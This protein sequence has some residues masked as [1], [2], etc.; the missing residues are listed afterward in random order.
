MR[1]D[2]PHPDVGQTWADRLP[3]HFSKTP[4]TEY[5]R[6]K[7]LGEDNVEV[8]ADWLGMSAEEVAEKQ[9]QGIVE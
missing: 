9:Q 5:R 8:L 6:S 4:V 7:V 2:D 3:L 1:I